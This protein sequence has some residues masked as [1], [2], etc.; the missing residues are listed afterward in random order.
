MPKTDLR[1]RGSRPGKR[2]SATAIR[3]AG[4]ADIPA[5]AVVLGA[6]EEYFTGRVARQEEGLGILLTAWSADLPVGNLYVW[7]EAAEEAPIRMFLPG[8]PLLMHA[9]VL[10]THRNRG[11]GRALIQ[12]A[13]DR[14]AG[15]GHARCALAVRTDN[16]EA[17]R[18]YHRLGYRDW[19]HGTVAC[20]AEN[21]LPDGSFEIETCH[22]LV[23]PL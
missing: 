12:A 16:G 6:A 2:A 21:L 4:W 19:G 14:L 15:L 17:A 7:L 18:L 20:R 23:K 1:A 13:E 3:P 22:V 9:E 11:I 10:P 5:L 8:V